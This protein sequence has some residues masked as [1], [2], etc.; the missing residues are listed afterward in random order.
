MTREA[1]PDLLEALIH[2]EAAL[3]DEGQWEDWLAL[4]TPDCWYWAP[5]RSGQPNPFDEVSIF[6]DDRM[7]ME[8]RVRRLATDAS[9]AQT[10]GTRTVRVLGR[11]RPCDAELQGADAALQTRFTMV[12]ARLEDQKVWAGIYTH[13]LKQTGD[14]W[15]IAWKKVDLVN[16]G[17]P[18]DG[19]SIPF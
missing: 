17:Q 7:L 6:Y 16:A 11:S 19:L 14:G 2:D 18:V 12:E 1:D 13:G 5:H 3:L 4:F 9:H 15:R 10:P 8:T